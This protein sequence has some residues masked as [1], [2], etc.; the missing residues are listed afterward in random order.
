MLHKIEYR[1][2]HKS[3]SLSKAANDIQ[4][5][6]SVDEQN[7][8]D[9]TQLYAPKQQKSCAANQIGLLH[10]CNLCTQKEKSMCTQIRPG[11]SNETND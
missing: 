6:F 7:R 4:T 9:E 3:D 2:L 10:I 11:K 5:A 1:M 8:P